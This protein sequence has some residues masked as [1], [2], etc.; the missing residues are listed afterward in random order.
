MPQHSKP[1]RRR[2]AYRCGAFAITRGCVG[3][4]RAREGSRLGKAMIAHPS[5]AIVDSA[6]SR[7]RT[8]ISI[9][10]L[11]GIAAA[12]WPAERGPKTGQRRRATGDAVRQRSVGHHSSKRAAL[13][14]GGGYK[15]NRS[16][17]APPAFGRGRHGAEGTGGDSLS[18]AADVSNAFDGDA[19]ANEDFFG[20]T[21]TED[22]ELRSPPIVTSAHQWNEPPM[23]LIQ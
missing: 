7:R 21:Q 2:D 22:Q 5:R 14:A 17:P 13:H 10:R 11:I 6:L 16:G 12:L 20:R 9:F 15:R 4:A 8:H 19:G 1:V 23:E 3:A 18:T